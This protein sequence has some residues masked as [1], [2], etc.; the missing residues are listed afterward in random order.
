VTKRIRR[1]QAEQE[2]DGSWSVIDAAT[3]MAVLLSEEPMVLLQERFARALAEFLSL[4][5]QMGGSLTL[6]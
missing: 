4:E 3:G 5:D 6:Q 2:E 1:Y